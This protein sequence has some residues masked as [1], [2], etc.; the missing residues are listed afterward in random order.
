[1]YIYASINLRVHFVRIFT[2]LRW[3]TNKCTL[4]NN[5]DHSMPSNRCPNSIIESLQKT[6]MLLSVYEVAKYF[7]RM[8]IIKRYFRKRTWAKWKQR[9]KIPNDFLQL[10]PFLA[11]KKEKKDETK[12]EA[13]LGFHFGLIFVF[14]DTRATQTLEKLDCRWLCSGD[15]A[16][17]W[18]IL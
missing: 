12:T 10:R 14:S 5:I 18:P 11:G 4:F 9:R 1:M 15:G 7:H 16:K 2:C 17:P 6:F 3:P 13:W 8:K